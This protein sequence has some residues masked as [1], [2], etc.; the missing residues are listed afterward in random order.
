MR[1][2]GRVTNRWRY[3]AI[4]YYYYRQT[5]QLWRSALG[6]II[7]VS[8]IKRVQKQTLC[9]LKKCSCGWIFW[10]FRSPCWTD[11]DFGGKHV[12]WW[13]H[14]QYD[15]VFKPSLSYKAINRSGQSPLLKWKYRYC[16]LCFVRRCTTVLLW[17]YR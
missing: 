15:I 13:I 6:N 12:D 2:C 17:L 9:L 11:I 4:N 8:F 5:S 1:D 16:T 7:G 14:A 10:V 3:D